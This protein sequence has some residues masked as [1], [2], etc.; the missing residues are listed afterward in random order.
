MPVAHQICRVEGLLHCAETLTQGQK[1]AS[2]SGLGLVMTATLIPPP[3]AVARSDP[4]E[5]MQDYLS[6]L[7]FYLSLPGG[8]VDRILFIDNS[9]ADLA[10]LVGLARTKPHGKL[11]EFISFA[12]NDHPV[13]RGKAY[14]EFKLL[15]Y[16]LANTTLFG[17]DDLVWKI[18][19]RL[20]F[21]NLGE[22]IK[23]CKQI[24]F[25]ILCDLHN[26]PLVGSGKWRNPENM[27]L[28]VFAFRMSAYDQV[29]R[30]QWQVHPT[31]LDARYLYH[32]M[33][34]S[35]A[36]LKVRHRFPIQ[37]QLQG[38]SGRH[39]RDYS[40]P[41]QKS[42]DLVRSLLRRVMPWAWL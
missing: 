19:G 32:L 4:K 1:P 15:D 16:G 26:I 27:D 41:S 37:A 13:Q 17:P 11:V 21:L 39:M 12:G 42:K 38:I 31:G 22:M 10:S 40:S 6:A 2:K 36:K 23:R 24:Q 35:H 7:E 29:F 3:S 25:D 30:G 18:T 28:R 9:N 34:K 8:L 33:R 20:R 14:G 5:R